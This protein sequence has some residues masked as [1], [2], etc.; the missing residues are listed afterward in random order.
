[1]WG[2][3][4]VL[5][6]QLSDSGAVVEVLTPRV[7]VATFEVLLLESLRLVIP[8]LASAVPAVARP[9]LLLRKH[10]QQSTPGCWSCRCLEVWF[11]WC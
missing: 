10:L 8:R 9:R 11:T 4:A 2:G 5:C 3:G 1:M 7:V 6:I